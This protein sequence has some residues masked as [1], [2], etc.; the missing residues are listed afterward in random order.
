MF[1][2]R[3]DFDPGL[4]SIP[5]CSRFGSSSSSGEP[6][7]API[8]GLLP[9]AF[10]LGLLTG[11]A[12]SELAVGFPFGLFGLFESFNGCLLPPSSGSL[13][14]SSSEFVGHALGFGLSAFGN[15]LAESSSSEL[16]GFAFALGLG[17]P[18]LV[19]LSGS[20]SSVSALGFPPP[21]FDSSGSATFA[22]SDASRSG[23][24][25]CAFGFSEISGSGCSAPSSGLVGF[26]LGLGFGFGVVDLPAGLGAGL[27]GFESA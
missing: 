15:C 16:A 23:S 10:P 22:F 5:T 12:S 6:R 14:S 19:S 25:G 8:D 9:A 27:F 4:P 20:K 1:G 21:G 18:P 2:T 17:L 26:G 3:F 24:S 7:R 11:S 13:P